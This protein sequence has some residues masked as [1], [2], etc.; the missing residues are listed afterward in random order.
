[1]KTLPFLKLSILPIVLAQL[2]ACVSYEPAILTPAIT[3]SV[4][5]VS[6]IEDSNQSL[7]IDFGL[8]L[9]LNESDSLFNV[10][11]LPGVRVRNV[12]AN[13]AADSAGIQIGDI[14]LAIDGTDTNHPDTIEAIQQ[15]SDNSNFEFTV[16]RNTTVFAATVVGRSISSSNG[17]EELYRIDPIATRAGY[18]TEL[19]SLDNSGTAAARVIELFPDSPLPAAGIGIDDVIL[20]LNGI[21]LNSAQDLV[22]RIIREHELGEEVAFTVYNGDEVAETTVQLWDPGRRISRINVGPVLQYESSLSPSS[23]SFSLLDFWLFAVYNYSRIDGER[24]H[25][26]LG[27]FNISSDFG[28]LTELENQ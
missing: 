8:E 16:Q 28:E 12:A 7:R 24:S 21:T 10:E 11:V 26:I 2:A 6:L 18:R 20:R 14:I 4:E 27:L 25:S 1:M 5:D 23:E 17:P 15:T 22:T 19:L 3:L 9:G 13:G